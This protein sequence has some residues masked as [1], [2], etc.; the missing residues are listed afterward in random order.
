M[1]HHL[2]GYVIERSAS[3]LAVELP[4]ELRV[5]AWADPDA[6][7]RTWTDAANVILTAMG[8]GAPTPDRDCTLGDAMTSDPDEPAAIA[9]H[10]NRTIVITHDVPP[11]RS[12][13][14]EILALGDVLVFHVS[15][16]GSRAWALHRNGTCVRSYE[17]A[18]PDPPEAHGE[19]LPG[20]PSVDE[21]L[22]AHL[23]LTP[24]ELTNLP[25]L[26]Y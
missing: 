20:E 21:I 19:P 12:V 5:N 25:A 23:G 16:H 2:S 17:Q 14:P 13:S 1:G 15:S 7:R 9:F 10:N 22:Q 24:L 6:E 8:N 3:S 26:S 18:D 4:E 11:F